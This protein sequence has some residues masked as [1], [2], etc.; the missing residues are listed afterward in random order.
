V[1]V[2]KIT[3]THLAKSEPL[4]T[5]PTSS[6]AGLVNR[7]SVNSTATSTPLNGNLSKRSQQTPILHPRSQSP[8]ATTRDVS[9]TLSSPK[10][11]ST[12][13]ASLRE[14]FDIA[15]SS[16]SIATSKT[17]SRSKSPIT[18]SPSDV[19]LRAAS[20]PSKVA[21]SISN[22]ELQFTPTTSIKS[23]EKSNVV[24]S[25][26]RFFFPT[27]QL[28]SASTTD[29]TINKQLRQVKEELFVPK[30]DKLYLE[31]FG[32]VAQVMLHDRINSIEH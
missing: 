2:E 21:S 30:N 5:S 12:G 24:Q 19:N 1:S 31:D 20:T 18:S 8:P 6:G 10:P 27:G 26:P 17:P 15:E 32:K 29:A 11:T 3:P 28:T 7:T 14:Q 16:T 9:P 13:V 25:I 22:K 23:E 4:P